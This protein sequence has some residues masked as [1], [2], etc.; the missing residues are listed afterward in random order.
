MTA[1]P[2]PALRRCDW[3]LTRGLTQAL[4]VEL[5]TADHPLANA[6][7]SCLT[8]EQNWTVFERLLH[9]RAPALGGLHA[10]RRWVEL[11][12]DLVLAQVRDL[13]QGGPRSLGPIEE[14]F[15]HV[16]HF[17]EDRA[18]SMTNKIRADRLLTL[19]AADLN[20]WA[21]EVAW[22]E[23]IRD[24]LHHFSG[25]AEPQRQITNQAGTTTL[26]PV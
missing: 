2:S 19:L 16:S 21:D 15:R 12:R 14:T 26:R 22:A 4:P 1:R 3:H 5:R 10:A 9:I 25:H 13:N 7:R 11:N 6:V 20:G 18:P 24:Y 17:L 8:S 23:L